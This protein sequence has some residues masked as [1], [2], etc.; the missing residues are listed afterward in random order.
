MP[1]A[2]PE[3]EKARATLDAWVRE[4]MQWHFS[5]DTGC[6]FWLE[7]AKTAGWDPRKE[8]TNYQDLD[9]FGDFKDEALRG[10]PVRRHDS[11]HPPVPVLPCYISGAFAAFPKGAWLPRPRAVTLTIGEPR[12]YAHLPPSKE[13]ARDICHDLRGAVMALG[14]NAIPESPVS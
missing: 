5:P 14:R 3:Q 1:V 10:G 13:T 4:L 9:K 2:A 11:N 6:Q 7:W 8:I 12:V